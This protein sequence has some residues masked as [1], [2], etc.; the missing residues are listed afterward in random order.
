MIGIISDTHD[1]V[2]NVIRAVKL[3]KERKVDLVVHCGDIVAPSTV[4]F[5]AGIKVKFVKGNCDGDI[6]L[7]KKFAEEAGS[8]FLGE[9]GEFE[10]EGARFAAYHGVDREILER[11]I[12]SGKYD[13]V[14]T[15]HTHQK[16]DDDVGGTR[17]INPGA[18]YY[19]TEGTVAFLDMRDKKVDFVKVN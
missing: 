8:E 15:G 3:F 2:E 9:I 19:H 5:F 7:I 18:H 10:H 11:L 16:R 13:Y 4:K 17:V 6:G 12:N 1:N 14:L